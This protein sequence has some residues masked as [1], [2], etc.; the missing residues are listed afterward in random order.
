MA[1]GVLYS[2]LARQFGL[3]YR[4]SIAFAQAW[5]VIDAASILLAPRGADAVHNVDNLHCDRAD[6]NEDLEPHHSSKHMERR[7][8]VVAP[9]VTVVTIVV[10]S[11]TAPGLTRK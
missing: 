1:Y 4:T 7:D 2:L 3:L 10:A 6:G 9:D 11:T 5:G 8:L